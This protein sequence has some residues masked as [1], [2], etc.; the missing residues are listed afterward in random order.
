[1]KAFAITNP[2]QS[3]VQEIKKPEPQEGEALLR[4]HKVGFCGG[5]LNAFRGTFPMQQ[6]PMIIG[7]EVGATIEAIGTGVPEEFGAGT[8]VTLNPYQAGADDLDDCLPCRRGLRNAAVDNRTMGVRRPGAMTSYITVPYSKLYRSNKLSHVELALVEPLTVG[9]HAANRGQVAAGEHVMVFGCGI[10]GLGAVAGAARKGAKVIAVD[11][12]EKKLDVARKA[13]A[14]YSINSLHENLHNKQLEITGGD[15]PLVCIEAVGLPATFRACVEE[16]AFTGRVVYIGYAKEAVEY[17]TKLFVQKE[18][19]IF[20][21]RN[22]LT[23]FHDVIDLLEEGGKFP[24]SEVISRTVRI[25]QA[26][27]AM[28]EWAADPSKIIKMVLDM[29]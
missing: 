1:M 4:I 2:G 6:Y 18:L 20:G 3:E 15:G 26:S 9:F 23:E 10:V 11:I 16:V 25:E 27:Q 21:S 8:R 29:D 28:K 24:V 17:D 7:H 5:D 14:A 13:G 22:A 12:D 19:N